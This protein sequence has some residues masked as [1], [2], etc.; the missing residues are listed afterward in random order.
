MSTNDL[1]G[2]SPALS[3][4]ILL[5]VIRIFGSLEVECAMLGSVDQAIGQ[6]GQDITWILTKIMFKKL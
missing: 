1:I 2:F 5:Q 3:H 4:A 6:I